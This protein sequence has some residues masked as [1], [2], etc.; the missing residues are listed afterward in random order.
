MKKNL[1]SLLLGISL[2][3]SSFAENKFDVELKKAYDNSTQDH[4]KTASSQKFNF[5]K[6]YNWIPLNDVSLKTTLDA[7]RFRLGHLVENSATWVDGLFGKIDPA[8]YDNHSYITLGTYYDWNEL[9][10]SEF[11][12]NF[13]TKVHLPILKEKF[14][15]AISSTKESLFKKEV[16]GTDDDFNEINNS[17]VNDNTFAAAVGWTLKHTKKF[18]LDLNVGLKV[19][20][21]MEPYA[22]TKFIRHF[23]LSQHWSFNFEQNLFSVINDETGSTTAFALS[24][25]LSE[26]RVFSTRTYGFISDKVDFEWNHAYSYFQ[27][28]GSNRAISFSADISGIT[29][30]KFRHESYRVGARYRQKF[31]RPWLYIYFAPAVV[32]PRSE[33]WDAVAQFRVGIDAIISTKTN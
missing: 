26:N 20:F 7:Q 14:K 29:E 12:F 30:P 31:Y 8:A 11:N 19:D 13:K 21:P 3:L 2:S 15:L 4:D 24:K 16:S 28:L 18:F 22:K 27:N 9:D 25:Q 10:V 32:F 6:L 5:K 23:D 1:V 33:D 17:S